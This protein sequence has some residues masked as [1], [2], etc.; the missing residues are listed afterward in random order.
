MKYII[1]LQGRLYTIE[2][3]KTFSI[4]G[5]H[6]EL[7][8][9]LNAKL[10]YILTDDNTMISAANYKMQLEFIKSGRGKKMKFTFKSRRPSYKRVVG[11]HKLFTV[12]RAIISETSI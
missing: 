5:K 4:H 9:K 8:D 10:L 6:T 1:F 7:I 2:S 3:G 12:Y 11:F